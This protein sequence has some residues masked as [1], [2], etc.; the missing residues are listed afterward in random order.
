MCCSNTRGLA[1]EAR[2]VYVLTI[3]T[4]SEFARLCDRG[5][6]VSLDLAF[7]GL[8]LNLVGQA[9]S[10]EAGTGLTFRMFHEGRQKHTGIL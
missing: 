6:P 10:A 8:H 2:R 9:Q 7:S 4:M 1:V 5:K 3:D